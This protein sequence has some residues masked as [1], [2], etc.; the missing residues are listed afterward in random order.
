MARLGLA[1]RFGRRLAAIA[2]AGL[3]LRLV[4]VLVLSHDLRGHGDSDYF[5]TLGH[6]I[7]AGH[8][9]SD[10]LVWQ[11]TGH[12]VPTAL[13]PPLYP[14]LIAAAT[15]VGVTSYL[16]IRVIGTVLG[17]LAIAAIGLLGRRVGGDRIGLVAAAIA[18]VYPVLIAADGAVMSETLY[19]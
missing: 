7:E 6:L 3:A 2:A 8:G 10:S 14:L 13:H 18:A 16:G 1:G 11:L 9:F 5:F 19:G 17:A 4:Y 15:K 12:F